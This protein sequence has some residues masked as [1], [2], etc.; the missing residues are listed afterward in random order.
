MIKKIGE[1]NPVVKT[2]G[3]SLWFIETYGPV[4][5]RKE[6]EYKDCPYNI[7]PIDCDFTSDTET[8]VEYNLVVAFDWEGCTVEFKVGFK[9]EENM[10]KA[11]DKIDEKGL[12]GIIDGVIN[13]KKRKPKKKEKKGG[14]PNVRG[15]DGDVGEH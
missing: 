11:F 12:F 10:D 15:D 1:E 5:V 13:P 8:E 3:F 7:L 2:Y 4:M 9:K 14:L 6:E